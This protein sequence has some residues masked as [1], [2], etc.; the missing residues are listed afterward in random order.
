MHWLMKL[1]LR[2]KA[3]RIGVV[4]H[5]RSRLALGKVLRIEVVMHWG[6]RLVLNKAWRSGIEG[7]WRLMLIWG[8]VLSIDCFIMSVDENCEDKIKSVGSLWV[9]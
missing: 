1:V 3:L 7:H 9:F 2:R 5:W 6:S 4:M 8:K